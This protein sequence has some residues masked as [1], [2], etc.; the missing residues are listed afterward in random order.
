M[1]QITKY[2]AIGFTILFLTSCYS[3]TNKSGLHKHGHH[4]QISLESNDING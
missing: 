4:T 3:I 2:V 1:K